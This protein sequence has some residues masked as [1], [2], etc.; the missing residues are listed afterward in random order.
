M[1][2]PDRGLDHERGVLVDGVELVDVAAQLGQEVDG[3]G[4]RQPG[5]AHAEQEQHEAT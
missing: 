2:K 1:P 4:Q 3:L 5:E